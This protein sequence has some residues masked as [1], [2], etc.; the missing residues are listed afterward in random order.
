MSLWVAIPLT[1]FITL[2]LAWELR[3]KGRFAKSLKII[4][5]IRP[6][7]VVANIPIIALVLGAV[8][9]LCQI[10]F[11]QWSWMSLI[12]GSGNST[13]VG[14]QYGW[15]FALPFAVLLVL[16]LP[17]LAELEEQIFREGT[18]NWAHGVARSTVFGLIHIVAGVP[19]AAGFALI[20]G[21][22]WFTH[23]YFKGG[24]TRS[25]SYHIAWNLTLVSVLLVTLVFA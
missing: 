5:S 1:T 18:R 19:L 15:W 8:A 24:I 7:M 21:G 17:L 6:W 25:T 11:M 12:G 9:L 14:L 2:S 20:I 16:A 4:R 10:P 22:L 3:D 23:Q 13:L